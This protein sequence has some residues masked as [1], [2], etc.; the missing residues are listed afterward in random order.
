[1][2][3]GLLFAL[4]AAA[5]TGVASVLQA[6]AARRSH[7]TSGK[8]DA[9]HAPVAG[10][11]SRLV[12]SPLYLGGMGLDALGFVCIVTALHWLPVFL[13]Q[14]ASAS[15]VGVTAIIGR[16]VLG[17]V[18]GR[19]QLIALCGLG[20]GLILLAAGAKAEAATAVARPAQWWLV[21][22]V[23]PILV[24]GVVTMRRVGERAG[25][26]LAALSGLAFADTGVASRVLSDA[27]SV[28]DVIVAPATYAL[29]ISGIV[30]TAFFAAAL[31]RTVVTTATAALFGVDTLAGS[32]AGLL[33]LGDTT[34]HGFVVPAAVGFVITLAC[35]LLLAL[36]ESLDAPPGAAGPATPEFGAVRR[37]A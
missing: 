16:R 32:A 6:L 23:A 4:G 27:R 34:R 1:M 33:A 2:I 10:S 18:L 25:G 3:V 7:P 30:G 31:Q 35:A 8:G 29:A 21:V 26:L 14:C 20:V 5:T 19:R 12:V 11:V 24:A 13:V 15:S 22:A 36:T 9:P 37:G 28:H 17:T